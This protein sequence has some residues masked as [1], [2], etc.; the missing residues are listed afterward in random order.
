M[1]KKLT[2]NCTTECIYC[3]NMQVDN[4]PLSWW[5]SVFIGVEK[6]GGEVYTNFLIIC[7]IC[8][9]LQLLSFH[10]KHLKHESVFKSCVLHQS[11]KVCEFTVN[12]THLTLAVNRLLQFN[13]LR[14]SVHSLRF[15]WSQLES[16]LNSGNIKENHKETER[17]EGKP[18]L[19]RSLQR[20][21]S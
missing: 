21:K 2:G 6:H 13:N 11:C 4:Q 8:F 18:R 15:V 1:I 5:R 17:K 3:V 10:V 12:A 14:S 16:A 19:N 7:C 20:C 9:K